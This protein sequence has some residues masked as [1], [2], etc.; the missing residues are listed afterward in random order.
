MPFLTMKKIIYDMGANVGDNLPYYLMKS[1][2]VVAVE[3]NPILCEKIKTRFAQEIDEGRLVLEQCILD[4]SPSQSR[5]P[6][7]LHKERHVWSQFLAPAPDKRHEF[8]TLYLPSKHVIELINHYGAPYYIKIDIEHFDQHILRVLFENNI[9]PPY[10]SAES[11]TAEVFAA[12]VALGGYKAFKLVEGISIPIKYKET[13][14]DTLSGPSTFS[15]LDDSAGPFGNDIH[16]KWFGID[17]FFTLLRY[18]G[19]G[20][21]DIH[22][23]HVDLPDPNNIPAPVYIY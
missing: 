7:Y 15:F 1:D 3:A 12:L 17:P 8:D 19:L 13:H 4:I 22:A 16:G 9:R 11:H 14:I 20:W 21:R 6:F 23:S 5:V 10:I 2:L 18:A